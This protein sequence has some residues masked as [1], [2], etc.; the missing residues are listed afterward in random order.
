[1]L[2][3][4]RGDNPR[5]ITSGW[6]CRRE[7]ISC[8]VQSSSRDMLRRHKS[9][10]HCVWHGQQQTQKGTAERY[11]TQTD[12]IIPYHNFI[13]SIISILMLMMHCRRCVHAMRSPST[14]WN[15]DD[16]ESDHPRLLSERYLQG[17]T[18]RYSHPF[19]YFQQWSFIL[20]IVFQDLRATRWLSLLDV[21][22]EGERT[23]R[24][25]SAPLITRGIW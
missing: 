23:A 4:R 8:E 25:Q 19:F 12:N 13:I 11:T 18:E 24:L 9:E 15:C 22:R 16:S 7:G 20:I 3:N 5:W 6:L 14:F 10:P 2:M 17:H 21:G 1:M